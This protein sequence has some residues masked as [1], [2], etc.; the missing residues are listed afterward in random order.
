MNTPQKLVVLEGSLLGIM[1]ADG[2]ACG[3]GSADPS[4]TVQLEGYFLD[5]PVVTDSYTKPVN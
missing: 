5:T 3:G 1:L 4:Y 2:T